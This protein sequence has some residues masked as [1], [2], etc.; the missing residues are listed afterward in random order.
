MHKQNCNL[1][2]YLVFTGLSAWLSQAQE[3]V[4]A[5]S[6]PRPASLLPPSPNTASNVFGARAVRRFPAGLV[7]PASAQVLT[8]APPVM[9][10]LTNPAA[11]PSG[12]NGIGA[13]IVFQTPV[14]DFGRVKSGDPVKYTYIFTNTGDQVL[15]L[16]NVQ[17]QCGCT[18]AGE[19]TRKV[20][21]GQTGQIPIQ[22]NTANYGQQVIK[23]ITVASN[24]KTQP[25][26]VLQL[27]GTLWKPIDLIPP[28]TVLN[29][30]PDTPNPS[31]VVKIVN[32]MEDPLSLSDPVC[33]NPAFTATLKTNTPG[34]EFE[35]KL[36]ALPPL[37]PGAIQ[38]KVTLK[39]SATNA[40][41]I[42]LPFWANVQ[43]PVM[44]LPAQIMI[45]ATLPTQVSPSVTIQNHSTNSLV[46]SEPAVNLPGIDAQI[47][48][49]Q[50]GRIFSVQVT[51]PQGFE[52]PAGQKAM[53]TVKTSHPQFKVLQ[54]PIVQMPKPVTPMQPN[55]PTSFATKPLT[56]AQIPAQLQ[57]TAITAGTQT[58]KAAI[59]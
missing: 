42:D 43:A 18:A 31:A 25:V 4:P 7:P 23:T 38:G 14:Y 3:L 40:P 52:I 56:K 59:Q 37:S 12:T 50:P 55:L 9:S 58:N 28:Y 24:D 41:T 20:E 11:I 2:F 32:N 36:T 29:I 33:N 6:S 5:P 45:P 51:L 53:L 1:A 30:L 19:W 48:E 13:R 22:F 34:K 47:K 8:Q 27:K 44:V 46:L 39:S 54:V 35:L 17:P 21:P 26:A 16:S 10:S 57:P 15:E 49:L